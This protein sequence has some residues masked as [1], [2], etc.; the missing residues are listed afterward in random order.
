MPAPTA[1]R[2]LGLY[3]LIGG[4]VSTSFRGIQTCNTRIISLICDFKADFL[5]TIS[6]GDADFSGESRNLEKGG[7]VQLFVRVNS[8]S[9]LKYTEI[10]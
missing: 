3:G 2:D 1:T 9:V 6:H 4:P 7:G 10:K 8:L 5:T